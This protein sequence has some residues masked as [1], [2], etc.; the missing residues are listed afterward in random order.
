MKRTCSKA[1][2]SVVIALIM[3]ATPALAQDEQHQAVQSFKKIVDAFSTFFQTKQLLAYKQSYSNS[4]TGV[5][6][7]IIEYSCS[8]ISYDVRK[9]DSLISPY[10]G[11]LNLKLTKK[12]NGACGDVKGFKQNVG[13]NNVE[14]AIKH[15]EAKTCYKYLLGRPYIDE[16][17]LMF[18]FQSGKWVFK[19]ITRTEYNKPEIALSA[20]FGQE[21]LVGLMIT[22]PVGVKF[23]KAWTDLIDQ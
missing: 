3:L 10:Q 17:S 23:N 9:T 22:E 16:V 15:A 4:P 11:I 8:D 18:A 7:Y 19:T 14:E 2:C 20:V 5:L 1:L 21:V 6:V 13:W 12:D